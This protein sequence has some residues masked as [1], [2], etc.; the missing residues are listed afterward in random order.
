[1]TAR[2]YDISVEQGAT[3]VMTMIYRD[4]Y[5]VPVDLTGYGASM[6]IREEVGGRMFASATTVNSRITVGAVGQI[7]VTIPAS[8]T[9]EV[10]VTRAVYD[11]F[12]AAPAGNPIVKLLYGDVVVC[13]SVTR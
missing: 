11:F 5:G 12:L 1:M 10:S 6:Q 2:K 7:S 4:S 3:F 13:P 9:A 8:E